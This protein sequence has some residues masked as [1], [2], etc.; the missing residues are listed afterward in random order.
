MRSIHRIKGVIVD[1]YGESEVSG[2][3]VKP[4]VRVRFSISS[5]GLIGLQL[6]LGPGSDMRACAGITFTLKVMC[7]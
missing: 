6:E 2:P 3:W 7:G 1:I 5:S 4:R